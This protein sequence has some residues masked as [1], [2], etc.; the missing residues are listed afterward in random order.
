MALMLLRDSCLWDMVAI[1]ANNIPT[2]PCVKWLPKIS[3]LA[4]GNQM[5]SWWILPFIQLSTMGMSYSQ[6]TWCKKKTLWQCTF[7]NGSLWTAA[8]QLNSSKCA[9]QRCMIF[10]FGEN[11]HIIDPYCHASE[12]Y[13]T[14]M[15]YYD[16]RYEM[17]CENFPT[18]HEILGPL[19]LSD[20]LDGKHQ[21]IHHGRYGL[22]IQEHCLRWKFQRNLEKKQPLSFLLIG[23][24]SNPPTLSGKPT[25]KHLLS[26][27]SAIG[28]TIW[29]T[30]FSAGKGTAKSIKSVRAT[31]LTEMLYNT[32]T[33][34]IISIPWHTRHGNGY[35]QRSINMC[36]LFIVV[37]SK[38]HWKVNVF[39]SLRRAFKSKFIFFWSGWF[40]N[41]QTHKD[42]TKAFTST[43][44][45][46]PKNL[47]LGPQ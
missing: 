4:V 19:P 6:C 5:H 3:A 37:S 45:V 28:I 21:L 15:L 26:R 32:R 8:W 18:N 22:M 43:C 13:F 9:T 24:V 7:E 36:F 44:F 29:P 35:E 17:N 41:E 23:L 46:A 33:K 39:F 34:R 27:P 1:V 10:F 25:K 16:C 30:D 2:A 40:E 14:K 12:F 38:N 11:A 47:K 42:W 20:I 31:R